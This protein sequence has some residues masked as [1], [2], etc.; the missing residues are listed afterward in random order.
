MTELAELAESHQSPF[1]QT[2]PGLMIQS[3]KLKAYPRKAAETYVTEKSSAN[4][5]MTVPPEPNREKS[6]SGF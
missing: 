6:T 1:T 5:K 2:P 3:K 4:G